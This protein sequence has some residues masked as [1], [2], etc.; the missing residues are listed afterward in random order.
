LAAEPE[1]YNVV[2]R[3]E[4]GIQSAAL[5]LHKVTARSSA[6]QMPVRGDALMMR[7]W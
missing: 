5:L 6:S 7:R 1:L 3:R 4:A 2:A